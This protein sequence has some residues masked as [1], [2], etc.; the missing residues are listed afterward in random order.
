MPAAVPTARNRFQPAATP[1]E[2]LEESVEDDEETAR[3]AEEAFS[4][5]VEDLDFGE[6]LEDE[7]DL[8]G[9]SVLSD[10]DLDDL[11]DFS[12]DDLSDLKLDDDD[13]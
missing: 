1:E 4:M 9:E 12:P 5:S 3:A 6:P 10:D 8:P 13:L 7:T 11:E 2:L